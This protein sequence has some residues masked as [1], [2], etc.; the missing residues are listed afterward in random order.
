RTGA[1]IDVEGMPQRLHPHPGLLLGLAPHAGR[2]RL[3]LEQASANLEDHSIA[4]LR[5]DRKAELAHQQHR[6]ALRAMQQHGRRPAVLVGLAHQALP[7]AVAALEIEARPLQGAPVLRQQF[8]ADELHA[9]AHRFPPGTRTARAPGAP[10]RR[11][12]SMIPP[13]WESAPA[14]MPISRFD[15]GDYGV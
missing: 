5:V 9:L 7:T 4:A 10:I 15:G 12:P 14:A 6:V 1:G 11:L 13:R 2:R 8:L 3:I